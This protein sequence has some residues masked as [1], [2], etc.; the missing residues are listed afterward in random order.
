MAPTIQL[1]V[2]GADREKRSVRQEDRR[3]VKLTSFSILDLP[4][5]PILIIKKILRFGF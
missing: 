2:T 3:Y 4:Y 5:S 1:N